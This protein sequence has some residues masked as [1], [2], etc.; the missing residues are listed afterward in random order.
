MKGWP[1]EVAQVLGPLHDV[2][3][4]ISADAPLGVQGDGGP[5]RDV[6]VGPS[7]VSA[8][9]PRALPLRVVAE[10]GVLGKG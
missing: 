4:G 1:C 6:L 7:G 2:Q 9:L 10:E 3:L 8:T 5:V